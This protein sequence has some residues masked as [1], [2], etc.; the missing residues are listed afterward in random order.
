MTL[1]NNLFHTLALA[2]APIH[3]LLWLCLGCFAQYLSQ[4]V[5]AAYATITSRLRVVMTRL[6]AAAF[7]L[8]VGE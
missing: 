8:G 1:M 2:L 4:G 3:W 5:T 7:W 6:L